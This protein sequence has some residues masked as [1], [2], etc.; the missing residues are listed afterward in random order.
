MTGTPRLELTT[1]ATELGVRALLGWLAAQLARFDLSDDNRGS[2]EIA[3]SESL[4]NIVEHAYAGRVDGLIAVTLWRTGQGIE[5]ELRDT[6]C[7]LPGLRLPDGNP[8]DISGALDDLPEGGF[9]WFLIRTLTQRLDYTRT[10]DG[11]C[12][13]LGFDFDDPAPQ[14]NKF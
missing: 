13:Q 7:A 10:D 14:G 2:L 6:G 5:V 12:L 3:V 11:N 9:G 1:A 4:N 8:A